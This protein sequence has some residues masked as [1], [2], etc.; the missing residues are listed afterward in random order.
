VSPKKITFRL[1]DGIKRTTRRAVG[2]LEGEEGLDASE[3]FEG[4]KESRQRL[5]L[6]SIDAWASGIPDISTRFH[7]WPNDP[8][9]WMCY[10]FKARERKVGHRLYG[11]LCN[12]LPDNRAFRVCTLCIYARKTER[13]SDRTEMLYVKKWSQNAEALAA[14]QAGL[15]EGTKTETRKR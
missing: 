8:E 10:T 5:M 12:P 7:G 9:C 2:F 6:D 13:D 14:I 1:V 4:L 15:S 3:G 11:Y